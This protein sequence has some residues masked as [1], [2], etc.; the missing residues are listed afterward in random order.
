LELKLSTEM[1]LKHRG[2]ECGDQKAIT[3]AR[4]GNIWRRV[5]HSDGEQ[6]HDKT[7]FHDG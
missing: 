3:F 2:K 5:R 4:T 6:R 7:L 1:Q